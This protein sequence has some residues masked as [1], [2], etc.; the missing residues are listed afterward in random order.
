MN[1]PE[2]FGVDPAAGLRTS[3]VARNSRVGVIYVLSR[4]DMDERRMFWAKHD[5]VRVVSNGSAGDHF[6]L[7]QCTN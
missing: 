6:A 1:P 7:P 4:T 5:R 2:K 3:Y